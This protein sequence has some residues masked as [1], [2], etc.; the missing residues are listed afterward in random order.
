MPDEAG[1]QQIASKFQGWAESLSSEEQSTLAEWWSNMAGSEVSA[2]VAEWWQQPGAWA[3][4]WAGTWS[5][6]SG[7][8]E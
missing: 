8:S 2:Y 1:I 6:W 3:Q 5:E 4:A 7:W